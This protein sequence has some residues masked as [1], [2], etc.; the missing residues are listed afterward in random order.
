MEDTNKDDDLLYNIQQGLEGKNEGLPTG[1]ESLNKYINGTQDGRYYLIGAESG[2]GKTTFTDY[3]FMYYPYFYAKKK[4]IK[5]NIVYFSLEISLL[6]KKAKL[7]SWIMDY[8]YN[9]KLSSEYILG[10]KEEKLTSEELK[11]LKEVTTIVDNFYKDV[12]VID[13]LINTRG[14]YKKLMEYRRRQESEN[15][16]DYKTIIIIDHLGLVDTSA[17]FPTLKQAMDTLSKYFV[18]LRNRHNWT[19]VVVQQFNADLISSYRKQITEKSIAPQR[20]DFGESKLSYRD[21]EVVIGL[22]NPNLYGITYSGGY[23][24]SECEGLYVDIYIMK[25]RYGRANVRIPSILNPSGSFVEIPK[26]P[27]KE[28]LKEVYKMTNEFVTIK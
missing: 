26:T 8:K 24:M 3:C 1:I 2:A 5:L 9:I 25:N 21:A 4:N 6:D 16:L 18:S 13:E 27:S 28:E 15:Q 10:R 23:T 17:E 19:F 14:I 22:V 7:A 12:I 20:A 11:L